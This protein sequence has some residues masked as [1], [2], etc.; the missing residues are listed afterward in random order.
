MEYNNDDCVSLVEIVIL[1]ADSPVNYDDS[2]VISYCVRHASLLLMNVIKVD[3]CEND[4]TY[5]FDLLPRFGGVVF[6][7]QAVEIVQIV[8]DA[9]EWSTSDLI[10]GHVFEEQ[11]VDFGNT[12][13]W[14][15]FD[16]SCRFIFA[17][18]FSLSFG[19]TFHDGTTSST[20]TAKMAA[21]F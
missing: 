14:C 6:S 11:V 2:L 5:L 9:E 4:L 17:I 1:L 20:G 8:L 3:V 21:M 13:W 7:F 19:Q 10:G 15:C 16:E 18:C 12:V